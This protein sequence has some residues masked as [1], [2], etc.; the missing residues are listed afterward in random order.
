MDDR[1]FMKFVSAHLLNPLEISKNF[2]LFFLFFVKLCS[3]KVREF[4]KCNFSVYLETA[5]KVG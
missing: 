1:L 5:E 4:S 3:L 2:F